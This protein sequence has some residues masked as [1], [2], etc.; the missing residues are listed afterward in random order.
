MVAA[1]QEDKFEMSIEL[2]MM[3]D[4]AVMEKLSSVKSNDLINELYN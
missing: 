3:R 2:I 4:E 1:K